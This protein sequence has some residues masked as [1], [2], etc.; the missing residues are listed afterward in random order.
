MLLHSLEALASGL[1]GGTF[2]VVA[3]SAFKAKDREEWAEGIGILEVL[4]RDLAILRA[5]PQADLVNA[6]A[7]ERLG[8]LAVHLGERAGR[9]LPVLDSVRSDLRLNVSGRLAAERILLEVARPK[10]FEAAR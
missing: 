1:P 7:R 2:A 5:D 8:P 6:D 4:L 9:A 10:G 3:G